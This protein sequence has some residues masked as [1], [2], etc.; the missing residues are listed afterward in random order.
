[1]T[2]QVMPKGGGGMIKF[3][4]HVDTSTA[5]PSSKSNLRD[6]QHNVSGKGTDARPATASGFSGPSMRQSSSLR[7]S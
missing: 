3:V 7:R 6:K 1:M 5:W 4:G 2:A